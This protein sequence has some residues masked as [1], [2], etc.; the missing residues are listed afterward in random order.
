MYL[1]EV[2]QILVR[3]WLI[4]KLVNGK[5]AI[6]LQLLI[7]SNFYLEEQKPDF[8]VTGLGNISAIKTHT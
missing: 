4:S 8:S 5:L 3:I 6:D 1:I 7:S 2:N